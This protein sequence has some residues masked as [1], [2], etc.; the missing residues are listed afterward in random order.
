MKKLIPFLIGSL[1]SSYSYAAAIP[2][3]S[4]A[5][6]RVQEIMYNENNVTVIKIKTGVATLI[7]LESDEYL[8]GDETGMGL[9]D[10]LAWNVS[11]RGN[12]IFL[13][14]IA[15]QP[16]TNIVVVTNKRT[17]SILLQNDEGDKGSVTFILRY[18]YPKKPEPIVIK[19]TVFLDKNPVS[20]PCVDGSLF[21]GSYEIK[22]SDSLKPSA[23]WDDGRFTC[24]KW[25]TAKDLPVVSRILPNGNEQLANYH[26]DKNVMV[27]HEVS[28]EFILRLGESVMNV[29][30]QHNVQREY[31][32]KA[33]T[34]EFKRV[35]K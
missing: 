20:I 28:P 31:N 14:P 13:R 35:E 6:A 11:V 32:Y 24:F 15:E 18:R 34:T 9:G 29:K 16:D 8:V 27:I 12:N 30:T 23:I 25:N 10:P 26:M 5:D 7:Q 1:L 22:G 21:N 19:P 3:S 2:R 4:G 17:Y 33:T